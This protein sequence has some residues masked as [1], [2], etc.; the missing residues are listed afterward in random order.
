MTMKKTLIALSAFALA[1]VPVFADEGESPTVTIDGTV[2]TIKDEEASL[3]HGN[4]E[5]VGEFVIPS[6]VEYNGKTYPVTSVGDYAFYDWSGRKV[7]ITSFVIPSTVISIGTGAFGNS[8]ITEI[9]IPETVKILQEAF[10]GCTALRSAVVYGGQEELGNGVFNGCNALETVVIGEGHK[11]IPSNM[12]GRCNALKDVSLPSTLQ[13]IDGGMYDGGAFGGCSSLESIDIPASVRRIGRDAFN[14]TGLLEIFLPENLE[15]LDAYAFQNCQQL[16]SVTLPTSI[17]YLSEGTFLGCSSLETIELPDNIKELK[18]SGWSTGCFYN[19]SAL[20]EVDLGSVE[21]VGNYTF[22]NCTALKGIVIPSTAVYIGEN[23]FSYCSSLDSI[24]IGSSVESIG[25]NC[26]LGAK[27]LTSISVDPANPYFDTVDGILCNADKTELLL[28]PKNLSGMVSIPS[29]VVRLNDCL[30]ADCNLITELV[31]NEG[32]KTIGNNIIS[33]CENISEL[34]IPASVSEISLPNAFMGNSLTSFDVNEGN[35]NYSSYDGTL[36][37]KT[38]NELLRWVLE[39]QNKAV[40]PEGVTAIGES[41]FASCVA[42]E[43]VV[44]P[45][46]LKEIKNNAFSWSHI[47]NFVLPESLTFIGEDAFSTCLALRSVAIPSGVK[48]IGVRAFS[49][50]ENLEE[51]TLPPDL[52]EIPDYLC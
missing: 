23:A 42:I 38:G 41:A 49:N 14:S 15:T 9:E 6:E 10:F 31:L 11:R 1:S 34:T 40:I 24:E 22:Y 35:A 7:E 50:C 26:F 8:M 2:Y 16:K 4:R 36:Y 13:E 45:S 52:T 32:L 43:E 30:F 51:I 5:A 19:C 47:Q 17:S 27:S 20:K 18:G 3:T 21:I 46:T 25:Y 39:S 44:L 28:A 12:F 48:S 29:N 33:G 37:D